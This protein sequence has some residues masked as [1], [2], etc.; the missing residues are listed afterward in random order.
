[1]EEPLFEPPPLHIFHQKERIEE[2]V[3][4]REIEEKEGEYKS[5]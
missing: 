5:E 1:M 4:V 2:H 3:E